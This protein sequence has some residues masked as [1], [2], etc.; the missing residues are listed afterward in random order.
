MAE[1]RD[2]E[3]VRTTIAMVRTRDELGLHARPA[4]PI[5]SRFLDS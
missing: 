4:G 5:L 3:V 1:R 2:S